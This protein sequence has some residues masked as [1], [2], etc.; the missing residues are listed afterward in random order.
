MSD[1]DSI[2][3]E[4][5]LDDVLDP[6]V[7]SD[8]TDAALE[9]YRNDHPENRL[10][11][12]LADLD[13][14]RKNLANAIAAGGELSGLLDALKVRDRQRQDLERHRASVRSQQRLRTGDIA[15]VREQVM[16]IADSWREVLAN[17]LGKS[18]P[19]VSE[20]LQGLVS[21]T[22]PTAPETKWIVRGEP[23]IAGRLFSVGMASP[24]GFDTP[25]VLCSS[26]CFERPDI[27]QN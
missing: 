22:P 16:T 7:L 26:G 23:S 14:Q 24:T 3:V 21:F 27:D 9:L 2:I 11:A 5:L 15:R 13:Q 19:I 20:L 12:E 17:N 6:G 25:Q 8:V 4:A 1:A 10:D 18:R